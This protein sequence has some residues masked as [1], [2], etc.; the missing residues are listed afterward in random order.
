MRNSVIVPN[1][2]NLHVSRDGR[3][4]AKNIAV[5]VCSVLFFFGCSGVQ[6]ESSEPSFPKKD[7][8]IEHL[9][10]SGYE[11]DLVEAGIRAKHSSKIHLFLTYAYGG[12]RVQTGFPGK[13][14]QPD[15]ESRYQVTN[16]LA[17]QLSVMQ[18]YW[19][20]EG[21]LFAMAWMPGT[22]DKARFAIF[23]EAWDHDTGILRGRYKELAPFLIE[24]SQ[25]AAEE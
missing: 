19:A 22:Y 11:C 25:S 21:N 23:L 24:A 12:I 3:K 7:P 4:Q 17:K 5:L 9:E 20:D 14:P 6:A 1:R 15:E 13:P 16:S 10:F 8:L 2:W 18:L